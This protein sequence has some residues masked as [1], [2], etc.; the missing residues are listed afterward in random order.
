MQH[1]HQP[2]AGRRWA[3][4]LTRTRKLGVGQNSLFGQLHTRDAKASMESNIIQYSRVPA[5]RN[6]RVRLVSEL[7]FCSRPN[8]RQKNGGKSVKRVGEKC[9]FEYEPDSTS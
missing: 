7:R 3:F 1:Y 9:M 6:Q 5:Y 2:C 4:L 8:A